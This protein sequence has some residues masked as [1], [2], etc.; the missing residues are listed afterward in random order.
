MSKQSEGVKR[1]RKITKIRMVTAMGGK[2]C[3]CG[4]NKC[5]DNLAFHHLDPSKKEMS[6][7]GLRTCAIQWKKVAEELRKCICVCHN[8]HGE[9]H[10]GITN[11]PINAPKFDETYY[12]Y[13]KKQSLEDMDLCPICG[14]LKLKHQIT[15]SKKC[16]AQRKNTID[17]SKYDLKLL[18][19]ETSISKMADEVGVSPSSI[20]KR[21]RKLQNEEKIKNAKPKEKFS[22]TKEELERLVKEKSMTELGKI[23]NVSSNAIK[24][25]CKKYEIKLEKYF[26]QNNK[27]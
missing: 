2:C 16:G 4:Y 18:I 12:D 20:S 25:R 17:W 23:Y 27:Y 14:K 13:K 15:C 9:I 3:I 8:C 6:F 5:L 19:D 11:I 10:N 7:G 21:I 24:K 1:W 22:I 26:W